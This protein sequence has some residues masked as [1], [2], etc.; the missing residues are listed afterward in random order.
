RKWRCRVSSEGMYGSVGG[1][2]AAKATSFRC[3]RVAHGPGMEEVVFSCIEF[4]EGAGL[5]AATVWR[6]PGGDSMRNRKAALGRAIQLGMLAM[7]VAAAPALAR[8]ASFHVEGG[9]LEQVLPEFARQ[10][11]LHIIAPAAEAG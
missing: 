3:A 8:D 9:S 2:V 10:A 7:A 5:P 1:P 6:L 11:G 4:G